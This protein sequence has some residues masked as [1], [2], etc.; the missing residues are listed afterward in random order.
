MCVYVDIDECELLPSVCDGN[1]S[2][3]NT[4]GSYTCTCK[5]GY[6][7][8]GGVG[9][10]DGMRIHEDYICVYY[11]LIIYADINECNEKNGGCSQICNN[12][13]SGHFC[14]CFPGYSLTND[15][16]TCIG[17]LHMLVVELASSLTIPFFRYR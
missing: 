1:A 10:C 8:E 13:I 6:T 17:M 5:E 16:I 4:I 14:S 3:T 11:A 15:N 9:A 7:G 2:C 12:T